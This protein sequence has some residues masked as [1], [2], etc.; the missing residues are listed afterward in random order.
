LIPDVDDLKRR[1]EGMG[2]VMVLEDVLDGKVYTGTYSMPANTTSSKRDTTLEK[3]I[4]N[5]SG[6]GCLTICPIVENVAYP[7]SGDCR[8]LYNTLYNMAMEF[9][10]DS[11]TSFQL[12]QDYDNRPRDARL[13]FDEQSK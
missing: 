13:G 12:L 6:T 10:V 4:E 3:R 11:R 1:L 2:L 8:V 9:S 5:I 7:N